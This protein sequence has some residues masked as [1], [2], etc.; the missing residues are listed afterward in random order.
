MWSLITV[1]SNNIS[2]S[3]RYLLKYIFAF[4]EKQLIEIN[5]LKYLLKIFWAC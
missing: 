1:V 2:K 3:L 4:T 5:L